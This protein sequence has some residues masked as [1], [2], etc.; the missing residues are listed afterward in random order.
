[1]KY[2]SLTKENIFLNKEIS[3][4]HVKFGVDSSPTKSTGSA[5]SKTLSVDL[6]DPKA[7]L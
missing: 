2:N 7:V 4:L 3:N 1:M 5:R 6:S